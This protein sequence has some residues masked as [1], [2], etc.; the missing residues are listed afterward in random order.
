MT[1]CLVQGAHQE[2]D[3]ALTQRMLLVERFQR[4]DLLACA[5]EAQLGFG[6][7][8]ERLEPQLLEP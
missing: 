2:L 3:E 7:Q 6:M 1:A 5:T 4:A 8:F